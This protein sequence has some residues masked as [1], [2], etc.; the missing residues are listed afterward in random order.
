MQ[1]GL[2][3]NVL[4]GNTVEE[5]LEAEIK[6]RLAHDPAAAI[7]TEHAHRT[8]GYPTRARVCEIQISLAAVP[9]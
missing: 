3:A 8:L 2:G 1:R 5:F 4:F 7:F 6:R 9:G